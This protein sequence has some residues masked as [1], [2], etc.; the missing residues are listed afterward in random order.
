MK[1]KLLLVLLLM[2]GIGVSA[3][4]T[5]ST[6]TNNLICGNSPTTAKINNVAASDGN[7]GMFLAWIDFR[8]SASKSIYVQRILTDGTVKFTS[9]V[10]VTDVTGD[11][12]SSKSNLV[13]VADSAGGAILVWQ[14]FRHVVPGNSNIEV[15]GQ[16]VD[17]NGKLLWAKDGVRLS[18]ADNKVSNKLGATPLLLSSTEMLVVFG[19]NRAGTSDLYAQKINIANGATLWPADISLHGSQTG[20]QTSPV[21]LPDGSKGAFVVWQDPR[22]GN[23]NAD[24]Y[25]QRISNSGAILWATAGAPVCSAV[26]QQLTPQIIADGTGGIIVTWSDQRAAVADGNIYAQRLNSSG[27][28]QW[29]TDGV[30]VCNF[31]GNQ[32]NPYIVK[33]GTGGYII[34]WSDQR[35]GVSDRNI[36]AQS[37][38]NNGTPQWTTAVVGGVPVCQATG[39]QPQ[40]AVTTGIK[41]LADS[42]NGAYIIWDDSRLTSTNTDIYAQRLTSTGTVATG[43]AA[44]G[45]VVCNATGNQQTPNA[46][47]VEANNVI[48]AW[49]DTRNGGSEIYASKLLPAGGLLLPVSFVGITAVSVNNT[50]SVKWQTAN[51]VNVNSYIVEKSSDG[52]S[53]IAIGKVKAIGSGFYS[54]T[55]NNLYIG[56]NFYRVQSIGNSTDAQYSSVAKALVATSLKVAVTAY[57]NPVANHLTVSFTN[58]PKGV[59]NISIIGVDGK[60]YKQQVVVEGMAAQK[61]IA[62]NN[63]SAGTYLLKVFSA[64]GKILSSTFVIKQ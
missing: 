43:W 11:S 61:A 23:T 51:E 60:A 38:D 25:A 58:C 2:A 56:A 64:D 5:N 29:A 18:V 30:L 15:Y 50:V 63:L 26:N 49:K 27:A 55:D 62:T 13:I 7:G 20:S 14:D 8:D 54:F 19:D 24:I 41:V 28:A 33:G 36:F 1:G 42:S 6:A 39:L 10:L 34:V 35:K 16:R 48:V 9:E 21:L 46:L 4:W 37:I 44:D 57:P 40:S 32:S 59:Y 47:L 22:Q 31:T 53:F 45:N 12:I 3:Q 52:L 17:A